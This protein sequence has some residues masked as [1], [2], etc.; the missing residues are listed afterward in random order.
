MPDS[1]ETPTDA[2]FHLAHELKDLEQR[3]I[4]VYEP[5]RQC[6]RFQPLH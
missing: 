5:I 6:D 4:V 3:A 1:F 2:I